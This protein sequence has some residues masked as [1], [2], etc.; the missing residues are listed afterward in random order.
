MH[1]LYPSL[2]WHFRWT[3]TAKQ[4]LGSCE[5]LVMASLGETFLST[6]TLCLYTVHTWSFMLC[7]QPL[8]YF[9][10]KYCVLVYCEYWVCH[11]LDVNLYLIILYLSI[12]N[13]Y[14]M[15]LVVNLCF[16]L[17]YCIL[18]YCSVHWCTVHTRSVMLGCQPFF[19][20]FGCQPLLCT[21]L[22]C[23]GVLCYSLVY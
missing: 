21:C 17:V 19:Y 20:D 5:R 9:V 3:S 10:F 7:C 4:V 8:L 1:G 11:V 23:T 14:L 16:V 18:L 6:F 22:L 13:L 15:I 2:D 12:I